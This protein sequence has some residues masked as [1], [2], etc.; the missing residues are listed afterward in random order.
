M[1]VSLRVLG[2]LALAVMAATTIGCDDPV[3][4]LSS[5]EHLL[6]MQNKLWAKSRE[7]LKTEKPRLAL[8]T[9]VA[10]YVGERTRLRLEMD[11]HEDNRDEVLAKSKAI[12]KAY[13][14]T[15][16]PKLQHKADR[17]VGL[18]PGVTLAQL[19]EAF[20]AIDVEYRAFEAMTAP[21]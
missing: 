14:A 7:T 10:G 5:G 21:K 19:R 1:S 18:R 11:Y 20:E 9:A 6:D 16:M 4:E 2:W 17:G 12:G 3:A 8:L 15:I 13:F